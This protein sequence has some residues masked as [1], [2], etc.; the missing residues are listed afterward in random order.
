MEIGLARLCYARSQETLDPPKVGLE[1]TEY[2]REMRGCAYL[3]N[4]TNL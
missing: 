1:E 3:V 4:P 2:V